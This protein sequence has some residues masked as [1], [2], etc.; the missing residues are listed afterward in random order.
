MWSSAWLSLVSLALTALHVRSEPKIADL[1]MEDYFVWDL[2]VPEAMPNLTHYAGMFELDHEK[3]ANMFFWLWPKQNESGANEKLIVYLNGGPGCSSEESLFLENGPIRMDLKYPDTV[4]LNEASLNSY[5]SVLYVDQPLGTGYSYVLT[6][7]LDHTLKEVTDHFM[8]FMEKFF[9]TFENYKNADL[10]LMGRGFSGVYISYF[11]HEMLERNVKASPL[12]YNLRGIAIGNGWIDPLN[13][14]RSYYDYSVE[15]KLLDQEGQESAK[16]AVDKCDQ[17]QL[18]NNVR[19]R[20]PV[21]EQ[22]LQLILDHSV[23]TENGVMSCIDQYDIQNRDSYPRCGLGGPAESANMTS[24]LRMIRVIQSLHIPNAQLFGWTACNGHVSNA[25]GSDPTPDAPI[26][27]FPSLLSQIPV[28]L[29]SGAQ[30]LVYNHLGTEASIANLEWGGAKGMEDAE[31]EIW[32]I[33]GTR[34]GTWK[35]ARNLTYALIDRAGFLAG[36]GEGQYAV[37][38]MMNR[39]MGVSPNWAAGLPATVGN[40]TPPASSSGYG[41]VGGGYVTLGTVLGIALAFLV[42]SVVAWALLR[43]RKKDKGK[44]K[45]LAEQGYEDE[46]N[47][48]DELVIDSSEFFNEDEDDIEEAEDTDDEHGRRH[49]PGSSHSQA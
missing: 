3:S 23:V 31:E 21:C 44:F 48:M 8:K 32:T 28:L 34:V 42:V 47:E 36:H 49:Q 16:L 5:A 4:Q 40:E 46:P 45:S 10:Y 26:K 12:R 18:A 20:T 11:A 29:Y 13:Q 2:P 14:Y 43:K 25:L 6:D 39:F 41:L 35:H 15:K 17:A 33:N 24:Y 1:A 27:L 9:A 37:L 38:N 30:S 22:L 19:I 7:S